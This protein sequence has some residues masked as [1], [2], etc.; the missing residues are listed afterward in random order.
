MGLALNKF[1]VNL[2]IGGST[3]FIPMFDF[4]R[5]YT[6]EELYKMVGLTEEEIAAIENF[7]PD[8]Y[9]RKA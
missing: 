1:N 6:D 4:S 9:G 7:L 2:A 5:T 3:K 8:Y